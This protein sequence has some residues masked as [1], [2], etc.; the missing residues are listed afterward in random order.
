MT[1][2]PKKYRDFIDHVTAVC[3]N[4]QGKIPS[5]RAL[6]GIWNEHATPLLA[7]E[8]VA[9]NALLNALDESQ[10]VVFAG[11]LDEAF[12]SGVFE[13]LKALDEFGV[14]P[15]VGGYEGGPQDDLIG[16]VASDT[17]AWPE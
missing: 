17:W 14:E 7:P 15:F 3:T 4:G 2:K 13:T 1:T 12:Q 10:R 11:M 5:S 9:M 6:K 16:R 8:Q